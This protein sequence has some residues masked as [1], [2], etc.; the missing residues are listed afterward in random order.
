MREIKFRAWDSKKNKFIA[1]GDP[2][3]LYYSARINAFM[4]DNDNY[5]LDRNTVFLQYTG[6]H[7][8]NGKEIYE[9]D[10][11]SVGDDKNIGEVIYNSAHCAFIV[12]GKPWRC[13]CVHLGGLCN[14]FIEVVGNIYESPEL[15]EA[16][17]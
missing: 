9:G 1:N 6:L 11:I 14:L 16:M 7:D 4:F 13:G 8:K 5:D 12:I 15:L 2:M 17:P 3:D 10:I